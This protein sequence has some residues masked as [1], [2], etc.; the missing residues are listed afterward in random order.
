MRLAARGARDL[1]HGAEPLEYTDE[2]H[3]LRGRAA[4]IH[5]AALVL[6]TVATAIAARTVAWLAG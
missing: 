2:A 1:D 4:I 3:Q 6:A 5:R